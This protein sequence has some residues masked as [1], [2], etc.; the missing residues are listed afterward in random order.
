MFMMKKKYVL[1]GIVAVMMI[2]AVPAKADSMVL[3]ER[4]VAEMVDDQAPTISIDGK[5]VSIYNASGKSL[6]IVSLTG[7][8]IASYRIDSP[9]Q[10]VELNLAKGCYI[11]K[12][13][14]TVRKVTIH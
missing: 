9:A 2:A 5:S 6:D 11:F 14:K 7:R 12:I 1:I 3:L 13:G 10:R 8:A 4:G